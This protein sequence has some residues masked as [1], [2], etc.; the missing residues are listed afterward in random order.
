LRTLCVY[1]PERRHGTPLTVVFE[2]EGTAIQLNSQ[3]LDEEVLLQ[4][5]AS[6]ERLP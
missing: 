6:M 4:L 2:R 1:R 5:A 3:N